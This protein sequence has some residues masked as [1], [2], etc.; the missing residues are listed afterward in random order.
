MK[1][2]EQ[3]SV[4]DV[5]AGHYG[6]DDYQGRWWETYSGN[7]EG[8]VVVQTNPYPVTNGVWDWMMV[9]LMTEEEE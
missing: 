5:I 2:L 8:N 4:S 7:L 3:I 9:S 6:Y 1:I